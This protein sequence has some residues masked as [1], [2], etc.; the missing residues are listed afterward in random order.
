MLK[1]ALPS[2]QKPLP[3]DSLK[4]YKPKPH[5]NNSILKI[6]RFKLNQ[7]DGA[8]REYFQDVVMCIMFSFTLN[9]QA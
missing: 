4:K 3:A 7:D 9:V 2:M 8:N 6:W 5:P 1:I